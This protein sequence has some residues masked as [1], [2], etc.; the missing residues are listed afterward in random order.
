M[1]DRTCQEIR[2]TEYWAEARRRNPTLR[3]LLRESDLLL[4]WYE[5]HRLNRTLRVPFWLWSRTVALIGRIDPRRTPRLQTERRVDRLADELFA[6][7][8]TMMA[9]NV[10]ARAKGGSNIIP[11]PRPQG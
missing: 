9:R 1:L 2:A 6:V 5:E 4:Q 8:R 11:L 10:E 7:Q 3:Q